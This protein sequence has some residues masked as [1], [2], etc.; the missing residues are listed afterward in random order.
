MFSDHTLLF[1]LGTFDKKIYSD[2]YWG[3]WDITEL[4]CE[5]QLAKGVMQ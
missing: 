1:L 5:Q 3:W 4:R 2:Q